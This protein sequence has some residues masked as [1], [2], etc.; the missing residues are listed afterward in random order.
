VY[1]LMGCLWWLLLFGSLL[2]FAPLLTRRPPSTT[3]VGRIC[4]RS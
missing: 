2:E 3:H 1:V 4:L